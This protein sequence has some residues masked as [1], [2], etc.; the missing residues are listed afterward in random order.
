MLDEIKV[1]LGFDRAVDIYYSLTAQKR[2]AL[3]AKNDRA[4]GY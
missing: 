4:Y 2:I 1:I 3:A